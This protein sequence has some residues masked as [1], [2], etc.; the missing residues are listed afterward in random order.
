MELR[1]LTLCEMAKGLHE[2]KF[3]SEELTQE[4]L[5]TIGNDTHNCF[6]TT[7]E[8]E[9]LSAARLA[10]KARASGDAREFLG[11]PLALKDIILTKGVKT[12]CASK[13]LAHYIPPYNG[14][15]VSKVAQSGFVV[16]GKTNMDEFAMGSSNETSHFGPVHNPWNTSCVPGGSSGGSAAAV[17][18]RLVPAALG[19]DTGGSIRQPASLCGIVGLKPTY[20]RVSRYGVIAF[21]SSLDQVGVFARTAEDC[22]SLTEVIS[23]HDPLDA[24]SSF[25]PVPRY[26]EGLEKSVKGLRIGIPKEYFIDGLNGEVK[27]SI[28]VAIAHLQSLGMQPVEISLPHTEASVAVYY[29]VAPA[30]ASSN[31]ARFDGIRYGHRASEYSSLQ[32]LYVR[33]RSEGF[34]DEVKRRI[35]VGTYVLSSGYYDAFYRKAQAVRGLVRQDFISAFTDKCDVIACPTAPTTAFK[36]GS[37]THDPVAM[38]LNDVFT[39]PVNLAGLPGISIPCGMSS[40]N[41]PIGL[42]LIGKHFDESTLLQVTAA[43]QESTAW[44][45]MMPLM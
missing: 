12:T 16:V 3:S 19:T 27:S 26:R 32:D 18:A 7:C 39:I 1:T 5:S 37:K 42:Q 22:A 41:L 10:D 24:T 33:S 6:I 15:V 2:R 44:H 34:G 14:T 36:I 9:A 8:E 29:I 38:Y 25:L 40:D 43:Y 23:G 31:L 21:A 28:E 11:V 4:L 30:E 20:G 45:T 17:A 35:M 13:M